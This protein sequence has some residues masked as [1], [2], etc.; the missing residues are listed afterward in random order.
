MAKI[1]YKSLDRRTK[2][3]LLIASVATLVLLVISALSE[4]VYAEWRL[5][6][7][8]YA[9]I[10]EQKATDER[11]QGIADR[12]EVH[13]VEQNVLL[14]LNRTDRCITC[15]TGLD[16]PRMVDEVQPYTF[17][18]GDFITNHPSERFG[19]TQCHQGQGRAT[20]A[21]AAHGEE[22]NGLHPLYERQYMYSSCATCHDV[23]QV[24][25]VEMLQAKAAEGHPVDG[26]LIMARGLELLE[27][28]GCVG[29]HILG[30]RGG[31][32][33][34]DISAVGDKTRHD[35]DFSNYPHVEGEE[36]PGVP[37]WLM[38]H[39]LNPAGISPGSAMP[40]LKLTND[41]ATAL[42]AYVLSLKKRNVPESVI[43]SRPGADGQAAAPAT[44]EEI[45]WLMC[46]ACHGPN[47]ESVIT[48]AMRAPALNN[49]DALAVASDDYYRFI[50]AN[51]RTGSPMPPW[52]PESGNLTKEEID[53]VV[54]HIRSWEAPGADVG[55]VSAKVGDPAMGRA[56]YRGKCANCH[57]DQGEGGIGNALNSPT[58]LS[59][60]S[61]Q[62][63]AQTIVHGR[64]GT[65]MASWKHLPTQ[66][67]SDLLAYLRSWEA[68]PPSF[69]EVQ[70]SIA[71]NPREEN[72]HVGG[73]LYKGNCAAC[74]GT[75]GEG[76][77][78]PRLNSD[79]IV[80]A[81]G[82]EYLYRTIVEGR[83][84]TA[85][86]AWKHLSA[87]SV[88]ALI[89]YMRSW[90][91]DEQLTLEGA[92]SAGNYELGKIHYEL[93]CLQ[94]HGEQGRGGVGPRLA[95]PAF[96]SVASDELLY[97]W[98][99]KGRT[100]TAMK[101][102][103]D[104]EQ[105]VVQLT[106][107][108][109][110]DVIAYIRNES[111]Q[112]I[113]PITRSGI[114][115]PLLGKQLFDGSCA[116]CHGKYGEGAS[117]PQLNNSTFLATASDGFLAATIVL[118]RTSTPMRSMVHGQ[119]G[120]DQIDPDNIQD[121]IAYMRYWDVHRTWRKPRPVAEMSER[122][123]ASGEAQFAQFCAGCHGP[124][125][126]GS[127]EGPDYFG[128]ALNNKEFLDA[129]SDGFLLA[130]IARGR[131]NTPMRPF[132]EGAGGIATLGAGEINDIVSY[133]RTWQEEFT[134]E[135]GEH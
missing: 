106:R 112:P 24:F 26:A 130:T 118:G 80:P 48:A 52:G 96:L 83:P 32:I 123:I 95:S 81:M 31:T 1:D 124:T 41:D 50:I 4:N 97:H 78:G 72:V 44:G 34:P 82:D 68:T 122:A 7:A 102:F 22:E 77:I 2:W 29:C 63:L 25:D 128:P 100:G 74:H 27:E 67:V 18:P 119:D 33:G 111:I 45:Y 92:P 133:I 35:F 40:D 54:A 94:C 17:H 120:I 85:M 114:G 84:T 49:I 113:R 11:G 87:D 10:L 115:N 60:V 30:G 28:K 39:F 121:I 46:A 73:E 6:R 21:A 131:S 132:G 107:E 116:S 90:N 93:A 134:L 51:G 12:F 135:Q 15:H 3:W 89:A 56:Y 59:I 58:F 88:G 38:E 98:I 71:A 37:D 13:K 19:C 110:A 104:V 57:G 20:E 61:D 9:T 14:E 108:Q 101:G 47:G 127:Q 76:G 129:A 23:K 42:T 70:A 69:E 105:G 91:G 79:N 16:D 75:Q 99:A 55:N 62:F 8:K 43:V 36:D 86:P 5:T 53:K 125:G 64:P 117:G 109:I 65:A 103:L 66:A 126:L